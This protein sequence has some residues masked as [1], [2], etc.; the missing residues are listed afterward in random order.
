MVIGLNHQA[1]PLAM[2]ER[3]WIGENRRYE[4]LRKL[5]NA[6][7]VV[8]PWLNTKQIPGMVENSVIAGGML[9]KLEACT[10]ALKHGVGRVRILPAA[11]AEVLS[12]FYFA[13]LP[14]GTEV[15]SA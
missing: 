14:W 2:R 8:M 4:V 12:E 9:P 3:F 10:N 15:T 7:G 13:K 5:K 11:Q 1:A 6:E